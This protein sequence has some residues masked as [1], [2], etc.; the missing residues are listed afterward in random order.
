MQLVLISPR[1]AGAVTWHSREWLMRAL[2]T[3][4]PL[5]HLSAVQSRFAYLHWC[6]FLFFRFGIPRY[7]MAQS[8]IPWYTMVYHGVPWYPWYAMVYNGMLW[9]AMVYH[10]IPWYAMVWQTMCA[11]SHRHGDDN[12]EQGNGGVMFWNVCKA[13][14]RSTNI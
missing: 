6:L 2:W 11:L 10:G 5:H 14:V 7:T 3:C 8:G 12:F 1:R 9:Y 4:L 13:R